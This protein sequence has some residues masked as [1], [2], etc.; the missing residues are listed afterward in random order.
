MG[1]GFVLDTHTNPH[2]FDEDLSY[3]KIFTKLDIIS[4]FNRLRIY[5]KDE[6][7]TAFYTRFSFF[8]YFIIPFN[9]YNR[10]AFF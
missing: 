5:K 3:I 10:P 4:T 8:K 6:S 1:W 9:L 2:Y 7:L